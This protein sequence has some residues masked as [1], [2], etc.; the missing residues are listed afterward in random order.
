M[1]KIFL[2]LFGVY[3]QYAEAGETIPSPAVFLKYSSG[4]KFSLH[5][6]VVD[7]FKTVALNSARVKLVEYGRTNEGRPLILAFLS[8]E[9]NIRGLD[10]IRRE[11]L[12]ISSN[13]AYTGTPKI[14]VWLSYNVHGNEASATETAMEVLYDLATSGDQSV[15]A[16][17]D[18]MVIMI[19]PCLN[20]DGRDRYVHWFHQATGSKP[21]PRIHS[22]EHQE[23]WPGG[24]G[25][26]YLFDLNR[27]WAWLTQ[28]ESRL[29]NKLYNQWLPQ[30]HIDFHEQ[31]KD[32]AYYFGPAAQPYHEAITPWQ[33][34]MQGIIAATVGGHFDDRGWLYFSEERFDLLYPGYGDTYP[35]LNGA[36]GITYEVP[37]HS[38]GGLAVITDRGDTLTLKD[39]ID[40]HFTS[41][42]ATLEACYANRHKLLSG[43]VDF[44]KRN[45]VPGVNGG[46]LVSN[47]NHDNVQHM[48]DLLSA[49]TIEHSFAEGDQVIPAIPA[50]SGKSV[51]IPV[52]RND[53]FIP[54]NQPKHRLVK[55][56]FEPSTY[57]GDTLT[58]DITAWNLPYAC[59]MSAH[60]V[61]KTP[62]T[63][64]AERK[65]T[66][67]YSETGGEVYAYITDWNSA[68][69]VAFLSELLCRDY[70]VRV[71]SVPFT[72]N[73][74]RFNAGSLIITRADQTPEVAIGYQRLETLANRH[75][76]ELLALMSGRSIDGLRVGSR[77]ISLVEKPRVA[78]MSGRGVSSL[79][80]GELWY[81]FDK[82][83][84]YP[85]TIL[86]VEQW[87]DGWLR[88]LDV[89][90]LPSG[91]YGIFD[92]PESFDKLKNWISEGGRLVLF[93]NALKQFGG[94][95]KF[96]ITVSDDLRQK[97]DPEQPLM[98]PYYLLERQE[99]MGYSS[100]AIL[101]IEMDPSHPL[102]WGYSTIYRTLFMGSDTYDLL[103][104]GW[105][106]GHTGS[107]VRVENG[108]VGSKLKV[109]LSDK[110]IFGVEELGQGQIVY[111]ANN[112]VF[113][114]F[115]QNG[116]LMVGNAIF[117]L[118]N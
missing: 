13:G 57:I 10:Q 56:L 26:H 5:H 15:E 84:R 43:Y 22:R 106:V 39:R 40:M 30:V 111:F 77:N 90:I 48:A 95:G 115:W 110:L 6:Q 61:D 19:D 21:D 88:D 75:Q 105:N 99:L 116:K 25:N 83:I 101:N 102:A 69:D 33:Y 58:Y 3:F 59:G 16:W 65:D 53:L 17:L 108:F 73:G 80:F 32:E 104:K 64:T 112:P 54:I 36:V 62:I 100:G 4:H 2:I 24:R 117:M 8:S 67:I 113:R 103:E 74:K 96:A 89:I 18:S 79:N 46:Y 47:T 66:T 28:E 91:R 78:L 14:I 29:R 23:P 50:G 27:D 72:S 93:G 37:G 35:M 109:R 7:Y 98:T 114:S 31:G 82:E 55:T 97:E 52:G 41:T 44:F 42:K 51:D 68:N 1:K 12:A 9:E 92:K 20:P 71:S 107:E 70:R 49:H 87:D 94:E 34:E 81:Y 85:A 38:L 86:S 63:L 11:N 76:K 60:F 45:T 118:G